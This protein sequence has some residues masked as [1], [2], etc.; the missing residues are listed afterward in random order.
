MALKIIGD[1]MKKKILTNTGFSLIETITAVVILS[2]VV[3]SFVLIFSDGVMNIFQLGN[4]D[5][6]I[7]MASEVFE[8]IY[9]TKTENNQ[10]A[11]I[12]IENLVADKITA[13]FGANHN[14][15]K[16]IE[17]AF[18]PT[19]TSSIEAGYRVK[20]TIPY[21]RNRTISLESFFRSFNNNE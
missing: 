10:E 6:A 21:Y 15:T 12:N 19:K 9:S 3:F 14:V 13:I 20:L 4:K 17:T 18:Q 11:I 1:E 2:I 16:E 5:H 8:L 7:T